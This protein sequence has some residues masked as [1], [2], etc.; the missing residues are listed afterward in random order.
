MFA[1]YGVLVNP[2][3][4]PVVEYKRVSVMVKDI[5]VIMPS[6]DQS[7]LFARFLN[8]LNAI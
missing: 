4:V 6:V 8:G 1:K 7:F 2:L 3:G 5:N